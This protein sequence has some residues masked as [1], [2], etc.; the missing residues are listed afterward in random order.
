MWFMNSFKQSLPAQIARTWHSP[1][2]ADRYLDE[3]AVKAPTLLRRR[4]TLV[5]G[6]KGL[7]PGH[8]TARRHFGSVGEQPTGRGGQE[9]D[10]TCLKNSHRGARTHDDKVKG[11]ALYRLN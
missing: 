6:E 2:K 8:S 9:L 10:A 11:L 7:P 3:R 4:E 5:H 1:S